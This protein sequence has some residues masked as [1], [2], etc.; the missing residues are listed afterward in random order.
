MNQNTVAAL[1][2]GFKSYVNSCIRERGEGEGC[3]RLSRVTGTWV[4]AVTPRGVDS[5]GGGGVALFCVLV[6][7]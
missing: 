2:L 4:P 5:L 7:K 6:S 3:A 1:S